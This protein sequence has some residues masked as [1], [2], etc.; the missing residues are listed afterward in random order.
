[1]NF[2]EPAPEGDLTAGR[3]DA[4]PSHPDEPWMNIGDP[5]DAELLRVRPDLDLSG[6]RMTVRPA[7]SKY[8][9]PALTVSYAEPTPELLRRAGR[10]PA[11]KRT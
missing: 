7:T 10:T 2:T 4:G 9:A 6:G 3:D 5:Q 8:V 11:T 1:M